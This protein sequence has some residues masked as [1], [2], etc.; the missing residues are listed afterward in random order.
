MFHFETSF[1][2]MGDSWWPRN[3]E[4][5]FSRASLRMK[6]LANLVVFFSGSAYWRKIQ[7]WSLKNLGEES[8]TDCFSGILP[9]PQIFFWGGL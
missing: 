4:Q 6:P 3:T 1:C 5:F 8:F 9:T 2:V 7:F